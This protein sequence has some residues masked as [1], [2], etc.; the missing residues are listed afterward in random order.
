MHEERAARLRYE[1]KAARS[2]ISK[3]HQH[4]NAIQR[5]VDRELAATRRCA[6]AAATTGSSTSSCH[7]FVIIG[8]I[9]SCF[10]YRNGT[11]RQPGLAPSA[12]SKLRVTWGSAAAHALDGLSEFSHVWI[13]FLFH[14]NRGG[15]GVKA[16]VYPPRLDGAATGVFACRSPHRPN[17]VGLSLV[18]VERIDGDTLYL[19][20]A[21]LIDGTPVIDI[22]PFIAYA[23]T[24]SDRTP[25]R[26]P[27]WVSQGGKPRL[28]VE[29]TGCA[30]AQ[31]QHICASS[32]AT[33]HVQHNALRFFKEDPEGMEAA[34]VEV[35]Q[36]DPRSVYRKQKC[37]G[38]PYHVEVD[39]VLLTCTFRDQDDVVVEDA[40]LA[41]RNSP[42]SDS[43]A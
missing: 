24:P 19:K 15:E 30:H 25:I 37:G 11:P 31:L 17:P 16:K 21:D 41:T 18:A 1:L 7:G 39:G 6:L 14:Q 33:N 32:D 43:D 20:G 9:E 28:R 8:H 5:T 36:A 22:K 26:E 40:K 2:E 12:R 10:T 38:Q 42:Y 27:A 13:I 4:M 35:L 3:L 34:I 23:D 29:L